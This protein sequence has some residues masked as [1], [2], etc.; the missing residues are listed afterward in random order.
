MSSI[1]EIWLE[2]YSTDFH[3]PPEFHCLKSL[4]AYV[5][6]YMTG[7][8]VELMADLLLAQLEK[9]EH[10]EPIPVSAKAEQLSQE[11]RPSSAPAPAP[12]REKEQDQDP[13]PEPEEE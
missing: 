9:L 2:F 6:V 10:L 3:E 1:L 4:L 12:L 8:D 5:H 11:L 7:S 13:E